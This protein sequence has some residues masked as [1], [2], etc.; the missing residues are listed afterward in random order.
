MFSIFAACCD[1]NIHETVKAIKHCYNCNKD[2]RGPSIMRSLSLIR[3]IIRAVDLHL[4]L[5]ELIVILG[6]TITDETV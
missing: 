5:W 3:F 1:K 4:G 6:C 2:E